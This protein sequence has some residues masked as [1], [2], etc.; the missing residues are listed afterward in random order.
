ML[1]RG[2]ARWVLLALVVVVPGA[3]T[4]APA[5]A[6]AGENCQIVVDRR[7]PGKV[8]TVCH[9]DGSATE[10][11]SGAQNI[12][13]D[14]PSEPSCDLRAPATFCLGT[15]ACYIRD[16]VVPYAP[17]K[18]APPKPDAQWVVRVCAAANGTSAGEATWLTGDAAPVEPPLI[19]QARDAVGRPRLTRT[20]IVTDPPAQ[21]IVGLETYFAPAEEPRGAPWH[22]GVRAGRRGHTG[23]A[24]HRDG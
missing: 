15:S 2:G 16:G 7:P 20:G 18:S 23:Q 10:G 1:R 6:A 17:P 9:E 8:T 19:V 4:A 12:R 13:N 22:V 21:S 14:S 3:A 11:R 24:D 5:L